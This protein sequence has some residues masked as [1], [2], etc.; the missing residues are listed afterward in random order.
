MPFSGAVPLLIPSVHV[1]ADLLP[2]NCGSVFHG[3][4]QHSGKQQARHKR[5][6]AISRPAVD[7]LLLTKCM[8]TLRSACGP[9][10]MHDSVHDM[11]CIA[12]MTP[13]GN[14][15]ALTQ[16]KQLCKAKHIKQGTMQV[17]T[18]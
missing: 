8:M 4:Q 1:P 9:F 18:P 11:F 15:C 13:A 2:L 14:L 10:T 17:A 12:S 3:A 6:P 16:L 7:A 5:R